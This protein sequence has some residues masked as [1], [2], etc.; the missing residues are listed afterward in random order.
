MFET[1]EQARRHILGFGAAIEVLEP[2][3]LRLSVIDF[4]RQIAEFYLA[5]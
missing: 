4:A 2:E 5:D 1:L 3:P